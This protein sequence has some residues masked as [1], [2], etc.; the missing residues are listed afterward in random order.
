DAAWRNVR[1]RPGPVPGTT[2]TRTAAIQSA[3]GETGAVPTSR[4]ANRRPA[5]PC[6]EPSPSSG[7][8]A[9]DA[10]SMHASGDATKPALGPRRSP[11]GKGRPIATARSEEHTSELQ[12]RENLV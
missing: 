4:L 2:A 11:P 3:T 5:V 1:Y 9:Y 7:G 10:G 8:P 6:C 12:S